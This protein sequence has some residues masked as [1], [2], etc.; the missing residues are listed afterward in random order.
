MSIV[1]LRDP[2]RKTS[3]MGPY[4]E[5]DFPDDFRIATLEKDGTWTERGPFR[6]D[7]VEERGYGSYV[8]VSDHSVH[9]IQCVADHGDFF[10]HVS[11]SG[12]GIIRYCR[13][14]DLATST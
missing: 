6:N 11:S 9:F 14:V 10:V 13:I 8:A 12:A 1:D 2:I 4:L 5:M 3:V 7:Q